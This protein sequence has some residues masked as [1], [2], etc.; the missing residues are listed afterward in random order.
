MLICPR[1]SLTHGTEENATKTSADVGRRT[2]GDEG[3]KRNREIGMRMSRNEGMKMTQ[4]GDTRKSKGQRFSTPWI[5]NI[6]CL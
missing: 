1:V 4:D 5:S 6:L 3:T 2:I